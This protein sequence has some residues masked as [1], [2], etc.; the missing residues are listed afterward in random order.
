MSTALSGI[1]IHEI[2]LKC[3]GRESKYFV[4]TWRCQLWF[5][6]WPQ[7][8]IARYGQKVAGQE[9]CVSCNFFLFS[10]L[11]SSNTVAALNKY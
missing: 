2:I 3:C 5:N 9:S 7:S 10:H 8:T 1:V 6:L 11:K 4:H